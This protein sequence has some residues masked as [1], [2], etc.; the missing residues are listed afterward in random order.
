[1]K[2][3]SLLLLAIAAAGCTAHP[4]HRPEFSGGYPTLDCPA[5]IEGQVRLSAEVFAIPIQAARDHGVNTIGDR[6]RR[7]VFMVDPAGLGRDDRIVWS[8]TTIRPFGGTFS[9]WTNL[10]AGNLVLDPV[11]A[12]QP[13]LADVNAES[14]NEVAT[15]SS[16][17][18]LIRITRIV[19]GK[20]DLSG[21]HSIDL[22]VAP[23]GE[24]I[25]DTV[26]S[27]LRLWKDDGSALSPEEAN[28][29]LSPL[30][31]PPG[32]DVVQGSVQFDYIVRAGGSSDEWACSIEARATL[33]DQ[34]SLRE[35]LW[36]LGLASKNTG[37]REW[38]ALF[39]EDV[40][41][42]RMMFDSPAM[43]ESFANWLV[44]TRPSRVQGYRIGVF[45]QAQTDLL[46]PYAS[47][48]A[49]AMQTF[50]ALQPQEFARITSGS[51]GER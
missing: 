32:L 8:S 11:P 18:G 40:G 10:H 14:A 13:E 27:D 28:F 42:I 47:L 6:G 45:T 50:R 31:H 3:S 23:G 34:D 21:A 35:P 12:G 39:R 44:V 17:P 26:V 19:R 48:D 29:I 46:R 22:A 1:M 30:R 5:E 41:G 24:V 20:A 38:L 43:A 16:A 15:V 37:R 51:V 4:P 49:V 7:V 2:S 36:D 33:I 25:D 9:S